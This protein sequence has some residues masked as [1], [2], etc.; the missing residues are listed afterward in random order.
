MGKRIST[1]LMGGALKRKVRRHL[2][3]LGYE[4]GVAGELIPPALDKA[5]YR[6]AHRAQRAD[7]RRKHAPLIERG[8]EQLLSYFASGADIQ[9]SYIAPYLERV[10]QVTWQSELFRFASLLWQVPVSEGFGRRLRFLVWDQ[11]NG[12][13]IGLLALGDPVFNLRV[14][15]ELI[16]W[17]AKE[18]ELSLVN[19]L[20]A[21]VIGAVPPYN[22]ILAGKLVACLL[23][24][25]EVVDAF[26][27]TYG[28]AIGV[29]S[30][31]NKR[32]RLAMITTTSA[33]GRS[34]VYNR[35]KLNGV[36]YLESIGFTTGFGHFHIPDD[37]FSEMRGYLRRC[38]DPYAANN[39]FGDG[40][41]WRM[42]AIRQ[43][44]RRLGMNPKLI[45]HGYPREVFV[46]RT[47]S[48]AIDVLAGRAK[49]PNFRHLLSVEEVSRHCLVRWLQPR[50]ERDPTYRS[51]DRGQTLELIQ[52]TERMP[53]AGRLHVA[54]R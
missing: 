50:A 31:E 42:R 32:P 53:G 1:N 49:R 17:S 52:G 21:Y 54:R 36:P 38:R 33:L 41:S 20:D 22:Q 7:R 2:S 4:R 16:G 27:E 6:E 39:R 18:R 24:T 35:L 37:L 13:L 30:G 28:D 8:R 11:H 47:A 25:R 26:R 46:C 34:S 45:Q 48:N 12:K 15:D 14:R 3:E 19:V 44:L 10:R 29:I 5:T 51:W 43:T 23:K 9:V 40:P